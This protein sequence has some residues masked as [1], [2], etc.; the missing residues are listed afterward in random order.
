M[1]RLSIIVINYQTPEETVRCVKQLQAAA[2]KKA[3]IIVVDNASG[4]NST[5]ILSMQLKNIE[6]VTSELNTGFAGGCALGVTRAEGEYLAFINSD[7]FAEKG[8]ITGMLEYLDDHSETACVVPRLLETDGRVQTNVA[9]LPTAGAVVSEY[10]LGRMAS[11]YG[12]L[13]SWTR[14]TVVEAFSGAALMI[15][16]ESYQA[17]GGFTRRYFMYVEDT[18]LS[19]QLHARGLSTVYLPD[20]IMTHVGGG[21][22][23][24]QRRK[25]N[26]MLESNRRDYAWRHFSPIGAIVATSAMRLGLAILWIKHAIKSLTH[27]RNTRQG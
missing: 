2:P 15:R 16:R 7:C 19:Y 14:P 3:Q 8:S 18:E 5:E 12:D 6:L 21:S 27:S 1:T 26:K 13:A 11:W 4:D 17:A 25:L 9:K 23:Q 24:T 20:C 10:I 22:S